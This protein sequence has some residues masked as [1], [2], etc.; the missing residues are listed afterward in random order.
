MKREHIKVSLE[1]KHLRIH[2]E[3][4]KSNEVEGTWRRMERPKGR[5]NRRY[6]MPDL[7]SVD[8]E[9]ITARL[10]DGVLTVTIPIKKRE[11]KM[12]SQ[13]KNYNVTG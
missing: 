6:P 7:D 12:A 2:G 4:P 10:E 3:R 8:V 11:D 13:G 5:F 1:D 9:A